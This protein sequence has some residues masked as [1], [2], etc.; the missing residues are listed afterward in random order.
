MRIAGCVKTTLIDY[1]GRVACTLFTQGCNFRCPWCHNPELLG[2]GN[3]EDLMPSEEVWR[4]LEERAG[5]LEGVCISGGEPTLQEALPETTARLKELGYLVKL[6]TNGSN[7]NVLETLI[8]YELVDYVAMDVKASP[9]RYVE[10]ADGH[11]AMCVSKSVDLLKG[12]SLPYELRTTVVPGF[13]DEAHVA[14]IADW[15]A[16]ASH[17]ALQAFRPDITLDPALGTRKP[18]GHAE[19]RAFAA[20]VEPQVKCFEL[21][22]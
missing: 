6:D 10:I 13:H 9:E 3:S 22:M 21:R 17:F 16:G 5:F 7:P 11:A 4:F 18:F 8:R 14:V 1:P 2:A 19:L 20:I 12:A 15:V